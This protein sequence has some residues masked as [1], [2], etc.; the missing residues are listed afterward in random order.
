MDRILT[1]ENPDW[2]API[3]VCLL[4]MAVVTGTVSILNA[5]YLMR[6]R[7]KIAIVSSSRFMRHL[8]H[9]PAKFYE[10]HLIGDLQQRASANESVAF[11]VGQH[12]ETHCH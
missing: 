1:G 6:I 4:L 3:M 8:L 10:Q 5:V 7:G 12:F 2:L 9:L 11:A